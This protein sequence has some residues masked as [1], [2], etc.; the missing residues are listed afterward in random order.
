MTR[1]ELLEAVRGLLAR[2]GLL[3][4]EARLLVGVSGGADSVAL[5][6]LL[7]EIRDEIGYQLYAVH[8]QHGLRAESS[9]ADERYVRALCERLQTPLAV[10]RAQLRGGMEDAGAETR[11]RDER[12]RIFAEEMERVGADALLTAHH[13]DDQTETVLMHLL[14]GAGAD[15]LAGMR[16]SMPF[17][18]GRL[19]RPLLSA[20]HQALI[21]MLEAQGIQW[22]EDESNQEALT[23]RN[24]L[25]LALLP[26]MEEWFPGA[27]KHIAE[28]AETLQ[29]DRAALDALADA[30][31]RDALVA[32]PPLVSL[33]KQPL[34][35]APEAVARRALRRWFLQCAALSGLHP[36]EL[37]LSREDT[38]GL[39]ALLSTPN[40]GVRNLPLNLRAEAGQRMLSMTHADGAPLNPAPTSTPMPIEAV[41]REYALSGMRLIAEPCPKDGIPTDAAS[42]VLPPQWLSQNPVLRTSLPG[43]SIHPLGAPGAKPLRRWLT[44]LKLD[45]AIRPIWPVLAVGSK[46]LWMPLLGTAEGLRAS[47]VPH[48]S[49]RLRVLDGAQYSLILSKE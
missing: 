41:G 42:A 34:L 44:D 31:Y 30:L 28:A 20:P 49:L 25:R 13:R 45:P 36:Q 18:R 26:R 17:G 40:G 32:L 22:R 16:P 6:T 37:S 12:R 23:P 1:K 46:V 27:G 21:E 7:C 3:N 5:F 48:G 43:D 9:L 10:G 11:A 15:G 24:A 35:D 38:L 4:A 29:T 33:R 19:L 14:R 2:E 8:V 47:N 39:M